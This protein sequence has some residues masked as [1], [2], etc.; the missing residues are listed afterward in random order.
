VKKFGH[1]LSWLLP[2]YVHRWKCCR[3]EPLHDDVEDWPVIYVSRLKHSLF[4]GKVFAD[5]SVPVGHYCRTW[6]KLWI[7]HINFLP[8][9]VFYLIIYYF[10]STHNGNAYR[11]M[12]T[13]LKCIKLFLK[14]LHP[15]GI[16]TRYLLFCRRMWWPLYH[17][18]RARVHMCCLLNDSHIEC[19]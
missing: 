8:M 16:R 1:W 4:Y 19:I 3:T 14:T 18:A 9:Y 11:V 10:S 13:A 15:G 2:L 6:F 12:T 5:K 7:D 17:A